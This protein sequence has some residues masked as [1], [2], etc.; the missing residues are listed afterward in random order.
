VIPNLGQFHPQ[1]VHFI[2][3]LG[4]IGVLFRIGSLFWRR[5]WL[6]P[7]A[8]SLILISAGASVAGVKSGLDA[9]G[10]AERIPGAREAVI[11]HEDWGKRTRNALLVL[12]GL[13]ILTLALASK[14]IGRPVQFVTALGGI[15][16]VWVIY[17]AAEHGG[18][19]VYEYA[20]GIGTRSGDPEDITNLLVAG[21]YHSARA[22][23]DSGRAEVAARL[24]DELALTR[25][26]DTSVWIMVAESKLRD[27]K[28]PMAA[29]GVLDA[30]RIPG[31][32]RYDVRHGMLKA[33]AHTQLGY[34]DSARA[35]LEALAQRHP[36]SQPV[37]DALAKIP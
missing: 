33:E 16:T 3:A 19:L 30:V 9:H 22:A 26:A 7:A 13:E 18:E 8:T 6:S 25:P 21:L 11:E 4:I 27:R 35:V 2:V 15:A 5:S 31:N 32:S 29:L 28:D 20:G 36:N 1:I 14:R 34:A 10:V 37:K 12:A 23:R 17:E 24:I